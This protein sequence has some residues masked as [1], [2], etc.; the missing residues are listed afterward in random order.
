MTLF[1]VLALIVV[2]AL[3]L[4][5]EL[6]R[7]QPVTEQGLADLNRLLRAGRNQRLATD[8][9]PPTR[10]QLR[11]LR[12]DFLTAWA[13]CRLL[14]PIDRK[15]HSTSRLLRSWLGFHWPFTMAWIRTYLGQGA[16]TA[17][18]LERLAAS[19]DEQRQRAAALM[20]IDAKLAGGA[21]QVDA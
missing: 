7:P 4:A 21:E 12:R 3:A 19:F 2:A 6:L 18:Q 16:P 5:V 10:R 17:G 13:V 20:Q 11:K 1:V 14:G 9:G 15:S 8:P